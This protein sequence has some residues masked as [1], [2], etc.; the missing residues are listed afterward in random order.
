MNI[1]VSRENHQYL[2]DI[3][4]LRNPLPLRVVLDRLEYEL[5]QEKEPGTKETND[6]FK[7]T[8]SINNASKPFLDPQFADY[9]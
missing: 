5:D 8:L 7:V 9:L 4:T 3:Q 6:D 1:H 2:L